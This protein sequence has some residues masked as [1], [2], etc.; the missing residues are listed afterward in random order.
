MKTSNP[1]EYDCDSCGVYVPDGEGYYMDDDDR[2]CYRCHNEHKDYTKMRELVTK[3]FKN[4]DYET[5]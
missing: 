1:S 3:G 5:D 2:V 4:R